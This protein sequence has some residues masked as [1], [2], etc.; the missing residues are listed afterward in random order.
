MKKYTG[1][2]KNEKYEIPI[3]NQ[4]IWQLTVTV[5]NKTKVVEYPLTIDFNI[6]RNTSASSNTAT[7]NIYNLGKS[8]RN[9]EFFFQDK[10]ATDKRKLVI[11][12]A[13]Y[14]NNLITIFKG[15]ILESYS[16]RQGADI[17]TSMQCMD[18][19]IVSDYVNITFNKGTTFKNA[20]EQIV[21]NSNDLSLLNIGTLE[22]SFQTPYVVEGS[23]LDCIIKICGGN[24]FSDNGNIS[25]LQQNEALD[26]GVTILE[27]DSGLL[28]TP[29]RRG[30]EVVVRSL[31]NPN[32]TVGQLVEIKSSTASDFTG[33]YKISG[34]SH[35]GT[36]SGA[37]CGE[38]ITTLNLFIGAFLPN[39]NYN[40]TGAK[41]KQ[42]FSLVKGKN[43]VKPYSG[44]ID[45]SVMATYH[46]IKTHNGQVPNTWIT[47]QISWKM[48]L[49][50]GG[51]NTAKQ[52]YTEITPEYLQ[53]CKTIATKLT[54]FVQKRWGNVKIE[55]S[56]GWRSKENNNR[57]KNASKESTH[58]R[59]LAIDFSLKG[60]NTNAVYSEF[61]KNWD[62]FTYYM[63][64]Y[65]KIHVQ[66]TYGVGG[67][68]RWAGHN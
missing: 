28:G 19:G 37:V 5:G 48:M 35:S 68:R 40:V 41:T 1:I 42:P 59:G 8:T 45:S 9:S 21:K 13:G 44:K 30:G 38:R 18:M 61:Y 51:G 43:N 47:N 31:F 6:T 55:V 17:I 4:C 46:Y 66:A 26:V 23:I 15:Y 64:Q 33:T 58:L 20:C 36:I 27:G 39:S 63:R 14:G 16:K 67:A 32:L 60:L 29:E 50:E 65:R 56:S 22:G 53:N 2:T 49:I 10:F 24:A 34:I 52:I 11:F 57:L 25:I 12:K 54:K 7:F 3:N 62:R